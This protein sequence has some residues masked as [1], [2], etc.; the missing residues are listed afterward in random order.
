MR[1]VFSE[2]YSHAVK[3]ALLSPNKVLGCFFVAQFNLHVHVYVFN[4]CF[5]NK[6]LTCSYLSFCMASTISQ[7]VFKLGFLFILI[8]F[9]LSSFNLHLILYLSFSY[10]NSIHEPVLFLPVQYSFPFSQTLNY[11]S[12]KR[13][14]V[15]QYSFPG[16]FQIGIL[17]NKYI[18]IGIWK[19][20]Q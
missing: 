19:V 5:H 1:W 13:T 12:F 3:Q 18:Q 14:V 7:I 9:T 4:I 11:I 2:Y 6:K 20:S 17:H 15:C 8:V 10:P 16:C